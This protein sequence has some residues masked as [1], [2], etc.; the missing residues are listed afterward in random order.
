ME[1]PGTLQKKNN[2]VCLDRKSNK[3]VVDIYL[4][5]GYICIIQ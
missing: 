2:K 5:G 3:N 4:Y 1:D